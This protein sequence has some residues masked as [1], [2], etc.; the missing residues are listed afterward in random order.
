MKLCLAISPNAAAS[1]TCRTLFWA[2]QTTAVKGANA[3]QKQ[4]IAQQAGF[5]Y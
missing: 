2:G 4:Q 5:R 3:L 1:G